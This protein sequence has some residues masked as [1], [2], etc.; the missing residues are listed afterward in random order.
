MRTFNYIIIAL[1]LLMNTGCSGQDFDFKGMES[2][3]K[4]FNKRSREEVIGL[5]SLEVM[6]PDEN[7]RALA[8]AAGKGDI[9]EVEKLIASGINVNAK[10]KKNT[11]PLFWARKNYKGFKRLLELGADPNMVYDE[12][13]TIM[14]W[15][16]VD[17]DIRFL[18]AMLEHGAN[19]NLKGGAYFGGTPIF[20]ALKMGKERIDLLLNAGADINAQDQFGITPLTAAVDLPDFEIARYLMERGADYRIVA[21][22]GNTMIKSLRVNMGRFNPGSKTEKEQKEFIDWLE[23]QGIRVRE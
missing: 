12:D 14:L 17:E 20:T 9:K 2:A 6:F 7:V 16:V 21:P 5:M 11:T 19:P 23:A 10:G 13:T 3:Q 1:G 15:V 18:K 8:R 22:S 4:E